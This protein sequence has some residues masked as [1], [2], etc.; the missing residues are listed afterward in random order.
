MGLPCDTVLVHYGELALKLGHRRL[1]EARLLDNMRNALRELPVDAVRATYGRMLVE[2]GA[3]DP[4]DVVRRLR[5]VPGIANVLVARACAPEMEAIG[6]TVE[7]ALKTWTPSGSFRVQVKR[8]DK[9]FPV[10]S[11]EVASRLGAKIVAHTRARVDLARPDE[12]LY[13]E[14][15]AER[16]YVSLSKVDACGGLPVGTGGRLLLLLSGGIDSPVAGLRMLRRGSRIDAVHFHSA[17]YLDTSSTDKA[18]SLCAV[19]ARSQHAVKLSLVAFGDLQAEIVRRVSRPLRVVLYRRMMMRIA[20]RLARADGATALVTGESLGQVASQTLANLAVIEQAALVPVLRPLIGM[21]KLEIR[22]Y[23]EV[24]GTYEIS[25]MP[26]QDCCTL[27]VPK[28]PATRASAAEVADAER[29]LDVDALVSK[30]VDTVTSERIV[31]RWPALDTGRQR[32]S[33]A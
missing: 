10:R 7:L 12:T 15:T 27:F 22:R 18:R 8:S 25:I 20:S 2:L 32:H 16:A 3:A 21:D 17:P 23:A 6:A 1:F 31:G 4:Q 29:M 33:L 28:H 19:M 30:A 14:I 24:W 26:D 13:V 9:S 5:V 11:P